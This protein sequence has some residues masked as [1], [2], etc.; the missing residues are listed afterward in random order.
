MKLL[1]IIALMLCITAAGLEA[2]AQGNPSS[3]PAEHPGAAASPM[4]QMPMHHQTGGMIG[5]QPGQ[6]SSPPTEPGQA[7]F[8]AIQE[9]VA[10]LQADPRTDW[11]KVDVDALRQP[12]INMDEVTMRWGGRPHRHHDVP[13]FVV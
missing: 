6:Q 1:S 13:R 12:L 10:R 11:S 3:G 8:A 2:N 7:A 9:I 5:H 4:G